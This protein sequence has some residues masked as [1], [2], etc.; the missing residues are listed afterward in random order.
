MQIQKISFQ[1]CN[2]KF[3]NVFER[4][5]NNHEIISVTKEAEQ[6]VVIMDAKEY[7]S[8]METLYLL[9]NPANAARLRE[10]I[11]QHRQGQ[12]KEIDVTAYLD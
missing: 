12:A 3:A 5:L 2:T 10:G 4:I 11:S 9:S 1:E 6:E 7:N 8:L